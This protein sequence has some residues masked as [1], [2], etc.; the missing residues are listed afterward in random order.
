MAPPLA[1]P[2]QASSAFFPPDTTNTP[3]D[4]AGNGIDSHHIEFQLG[5]APNVMKVETVVGASGV[6]SQKV[7]D[8]LESLKLRLLEVYEN[9]S[10]LV[11]FG[12]SE[13][14][15]R[16]TNM[17]TKPI[18]VNS[19]SL[20]EQI[21]AQFGQARID[22]LKLSDNVTL[23]SIEK[24]TQTDANAF[25]YHSGTITFQVAGKPDRKIKFREFCPDYDGRSLDSA[26]LRAALKHVPKPKSE[27]SHAANTPCPQLYS[28]NGIG[29]SASLAVLYSFK[30]MCAQ[31]NGVKPALVERHLKTLINQGREQR[32]AH[33]VNSQE[34]LKQ[35]LE[36]CTVVNAEVGVN[37]TIKHL[38][39]DKPLF[40][41]K[42]HQFPYMPIKV[43][44]IVKIA[45]DPDKFP[46]PQLDLE[47]ANEYASD[48]IKAGY[49][50]DALGADLESHFYVRPEGNTDDEPLRKDVLE[51]KLG[52][53]EKREYRASPNQADKDKILIAQLKKHNRNGH[54]ATDDTQQGALSAN[55]KIRWIV[56]DKGDLNELGKKILS[57][58]RESKFP[59]KGQQLG[60]APETD[61]VI[62]G[63]ADTLT[64]CQ[65][66][67]L[68]QEWKDQCIPDLR[69][70]DRRSGGAGNGGMM[71]I[72]YDL[73]PL[74]ASGASMKDLV[75][76]ALI[77]NQ[78]THHGSLSTVASVGQVVLMAKCMH[79]RKVAE[80]QD[81]K[82]VPPKNFFID[83]FYE[84][85]KVLEHPDQL[86]GL[87]GN[88]VP[89]GDGSNWR[90]PRLP[91]EFL[92][93]RSAQGLTEPREITKA[94][95]VT[96]GSVLTALETYKDKTQLNSI[97]TNEVLQR[98]CS[99]AYLGATFPSIVFLLEK[100]G[101]DP[102][103]AVNM[104]ALVTKDSD[105]C[106]TIIAQVMGAL[107]GSAWV[108]EE[109]KSCEDG[110]HRS[111][112]NE[113]LGGGFTLKNFI[114]HMSNFY[115]KRE[116]QTQ[117]TTTT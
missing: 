37:E 7:H 104:A 74:L 106:A 61:F 85:A 58:F 33:F 29:R 97:E 53:D 40:A 12:S 62:R 63:G 25:K 71:R 39:E 115:D 69:N 68:K 92:K 100:F 77:S 110:D 54:H 8:A 109:I 103:H 51:A 101:N 48:V 67:P 78:V 34:Q 117:S 1:S 90:T 65:R 24:K 10:C 43:D 59:E 99:R 26:T 3:N 45:S 88:A 107:H 55:A 79:L 75:Q 14:F 70:S 18:K 9:G 60:D 64:M 20:L 93:G 108:H 31:Q 11:S 66:R 21:L 47:N 98:W 35:L 52:K 95:S 16:I 15:D 6:E 17:Q 102:A 76:Q 81:E 27:D 73:L 57:A 5:T 80:Q 19:S 84:I 96:A 113:D 23:K 56:E 50:G 86:F 32:H 111:T 49:Y 44:G 38:V 4:P 41:G 30:E 94:N 114:D 72:G 28:A 112:F 22:G 42:E 89:V 83:T 87:D 116:K 2:R 36:A 91:S 13:S 105:T 82:P 46:F